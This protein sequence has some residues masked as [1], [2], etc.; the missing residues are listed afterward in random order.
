MAGPLPV[1]Q[2]TRILQAG[3]DEPSALAA[4]Q[5]FNQLLAAVV[6]WVEWRVWRGTLSGADSQA[7]MAMALNFRFVTVSPK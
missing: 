5:R 3:L 6:I 1:D 2:A 7:N 4:R